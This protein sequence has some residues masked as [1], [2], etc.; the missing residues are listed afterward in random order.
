MTAE[1]PR[2]ILFTAYAINDAYLRF[3]MS[4]TRILN[5]LFGHIVEEPAECM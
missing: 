5:P 1:Y 3:C 4:N 2:D